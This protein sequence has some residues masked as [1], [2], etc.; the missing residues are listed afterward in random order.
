[1]VTEKI[2]VKRIV[3][4]EFLYE[5]VV[6]ALREKIN[7]CERSGNLLA[8]DNYNSLLADIEEERWQDLE[9]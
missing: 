8:L 2:S 7:K 6:N 9:L 1:M 5:L 4:D 3:L